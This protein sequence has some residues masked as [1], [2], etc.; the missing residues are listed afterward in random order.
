[1]IF[2]KKLLKAALAIA[3]AQ[4]LIL[5]APA[6]RQ[7]S[8]APE[9]TPSQQKM[10]TLIDK[11]MPTLNYEA[12]C[13]DKKDNDRD[14]RTDCEDEDCYLNDAC[15]KERGR[16]IHCFD[17]ID[18]DL[19]GK[20][21]CFDPDCA[22]RQ[23]CTPKYDPCTPNP[24][25][26]IS[27][28]LADRLTLK[29]T[30]GRCQVQDHRPVCLFPEEAAEAINCA[31]TERICL[32]DK[33]SDTIDLLKK[34]PSG[35]YKGFLDRVLVTH[36]DKRMN[37]LYLQHSPEGP[38][39]AV[40]LKHNREFNNVAPGNIISL[41]F[42]KM[43]THEGIN[44][45]SSAKARLAANDSLHHDLAPFIQKI[46]ADSA[47]TFTA[48]D[49]GK[50]FSFKA[51]F[52]R[53]LITG[54]RR[55][56]ASYGDNHDLIVSLPEKQYLKTLPEAGMIFE[57]APLPL[58]LEKDLPLIYLSSSDFSVSGRITAEERCAIF[59]KAAFSLTHLGSSAGRAVSVKVEPIPLADSYDLALIAADGSSLEYAAALPSNTT[60]WQSQK[61]APEKYRFK[62][63]AHAKE[64]RDREIISDWF[65][66]KA[67]DPCAAGDLFISQVTSGSCRQKTP[68][69][70]EIYNN[71][72]VTIML[73]G[74][75]IR[76]VMNPDKESGL[77][78]SSEI[79]LA[80]GSSL[81]P[82]SAMVIGLPY[83]DESG[84][85]YT[86]DL[87]LKNFYINGDDIIGLFDQN[88]LLLDI[89][90]A[91]PTDG[92]SD[93]Y[94]NYREASVERAKGFGASPTFS[95]KENFA[96]EWQ[97]KP[98]GCVSAAAAGLGKH[99]P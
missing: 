78:W 36:L 18:N 87:P 60:F 73:G 29:K 49:F 77:S 53:P 32:T 12:D 76:A 34:R 16:E 17:G 84:Q 2:T 59:A 20:I 63:R 61:A 10:A 82:K 65:T 35:G 4:A 90:G 19:D 26:T 11:A 85:K 33:C 30:T 66:P 27:Q 8:A 41:Q 52:I 67:K 1:M 44:Y 75:K 71:C 22:A 81:A 37:M 13:R 47:R 70:I 57:S 89:Y 45:I 38:A 64:C 39:I 98:L 69:A 3:L 31:D 91:P 96:S 24:C 7:K 25:D 94:W 97:K 92:S 48:D 23:G 42:N 62:V 72:P 5:G 88:D 83:I 55:W 68:K 50:L 6:C 79:A 21:D 14:G 51:V 93:F 74:F 80:D 43:Y 99:T 46:T 15:T 86:P 40:D 58:A 28:C 95:S 56:L 9:L 54:G